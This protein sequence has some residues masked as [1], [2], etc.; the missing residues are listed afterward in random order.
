MDVIRIDDLEIFAY[1]GVTK[2]ER[3]TGQRFLINVE[4]FLDLTGA[5]SADDIKQTVDYAEVVELIRDFMGRTKYFLIEAVAQKLSERILLEYEDFVSRVKVTVKK[6]QAPI[7]VSFKSCDVSVE[8]GWHRAFISVGS[9]MGDRKKYLKKAYTALDSDPL[10][11]V[12]NASEIIETEPYGYADQDD[13][14]DQVIEIKTIL[15]PMQLLKLCHDTE[16]KCK[17]ERTLRWG[18]RTLDMDIVFYDDEVINTP[19][20][21]IPHY[22]M[23]NRDFVLRPLYQIAPYFIHPVSHKSVKQLILELRKESVK[24]ERDE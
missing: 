4:M 20:L 6:P 12:V 3:M 13:F 1:H 16:A 23:E 8:R 22:D 10:T 19:D 11:H 17:R 21:I 18:P 2:A 14:L 7:P 9:N 15:S 5:G 24:R